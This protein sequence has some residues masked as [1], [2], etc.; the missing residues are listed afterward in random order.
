MRQGHYISTNLV[1]I[2]LLDGASCNLETSVSVVAEPVEQATAADTPLTRRLVAAPAPSRSPRPGVG[3]LLAASGA[4]VLA[5]LAVR[6]LETHVAPFPW[7]VWAA[8]VGSSHKAWLVWKL[9][10][11]YQQMGRPLVAVGEVLV[12][13]AW[14]WRSAGP[15]AT[16]GLC[17]VLM[18]SLACG[19]I[20]TFC[21]PTPLWLSLHHVGSNFPSGVVTFVTATGG[22]LA[23]VA[24]QQGRRLLPA[25]LVAIIVG[26]GP[27]RVLGAQHVATDAAAGYGLGLAGLLW[28]RAFMDSG[29][30]QRLVARLDH[31]LPQRA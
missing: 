15:R 7:D 13:F 8:R 14:C 1:D 18:A 3:L 6:L 10:R 22:Y 12:M 28:A 30:S 25:V 19:V 16:L 17:V 23:W 26:A 24:H 4:L 21:G 27:A 11:A 5:V 2:L 31:L 20:K 9:T 29:L